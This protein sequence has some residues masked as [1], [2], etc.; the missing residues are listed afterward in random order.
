MRYTRYDYKKNKGDN[1]LIWLIGIIV[2][3]V[4]IGMLLYNVFLKKTDII[5]V[6]NHNNKKTETVVENKE[7]T[8]QEFGIIQCGVFKDR[9]NAEATLNSV[10]SESTGFI[11]EEDGGFK[12]IYGIY[13]FNDAGAKSDSL[14]ASSISNFR[15]KC[16]LEDDTEEKKAESEIIDAYIKVVNKLTEKDVKSVNIKEFKTWTNTVSEDV[17]NNSD[18]FL[19]LV[20]H[21][22]EL[23]DEYKKENQKESLIN[24]YTILKKYKQK[25]IIKKKLKSV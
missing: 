25:W 18:E 11:V 24:I 4:C 13:R 17:K 16:I 8:N 20:K 7:E 21:I 15:I 2:F 14:T 19:N 3:S 22:N 1:F 10:N 9:A 5:E 12:L 23:P 6:N